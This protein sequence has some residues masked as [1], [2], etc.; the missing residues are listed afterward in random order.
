MADDT[1]KQDNRDRSKVSA[2]EDYEINYIVKKMGVTVEQVR[3]AIENV[4]NHR[5]RIEGFLANKK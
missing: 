5:E 3:E 1:N 2:S 4:G